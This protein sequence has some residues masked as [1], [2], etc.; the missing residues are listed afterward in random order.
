[1]EVVGHDHELHPKQPLDQEAVE[2]RL[3]ASAKVSSKQ[4]QIQRFSCTFAQDQD[5]GSTA[6]PADDEQDLQFGREEALRMDEEV[7]DVPVVRQHPVGQHQGPAW[8]DVRSTPD[9]SSLL[10]N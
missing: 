1:M 4:Q 9:T 10:C 3:L 8:H 5:L 6:A 7:M 2:A